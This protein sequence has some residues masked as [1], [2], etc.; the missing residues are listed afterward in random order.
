M[1]A[2]TLLLRSVVLF[3]VAVAAAVF[4]VVALAVNVSPGG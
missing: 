2:T 1:P 4:P 3:A